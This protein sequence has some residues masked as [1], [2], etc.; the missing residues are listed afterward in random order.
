[1]LPPSWTQYDVIEFE[2]CDEERDWGYVKYGV[3]VSRTR[4]EIFLLYCGKEAHV[5]VG[6]ARKWQGEERFNSLEEGDE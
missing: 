5:A 1:M 3:I 2:N 4:N 6:L